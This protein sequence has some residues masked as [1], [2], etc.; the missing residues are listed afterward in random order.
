[1]FGGLIFSK[2]TLNLEPAQQ[3]DPLRFVKIQIFHEGYYNAFLQVVRLVYK[4][5]N[6]QT[7]ALSGH[8][9]SSYIDNYIISSIAHCIRYP[10]KDSKM[11]EDFKILI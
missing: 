4:T 2:W 10:S 5:A 6:E 9:E 8:Q 1:M 3:E 11:L 7:L